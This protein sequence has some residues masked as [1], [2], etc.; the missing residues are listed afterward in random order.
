MKEATTPANPLPVR[1]PGL[2]PNRFPEITYL[3]IQFPNE[4]VSVGDSWKFTRTFEGADMTYTCTLS[5]MDDASAKIAVKVHQEQL[6][7]E[8]SS[9]EVVKSKADA[10][11]EVRTILDGQGTITWDRK[12]GLANVVEMTNDATS[13]VTP[14]S[15]GTAETRKLKTTFRV[16]RQGAPNA[17]IVANAPKA[18]NQW[19]A[20]GEQAWNTTKLWA[21][22]ATNQ[23]AKQPISRQAAVAWQQAFGWAF[24]LWNHGR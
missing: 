20:W 24:K 3:P 7:Y 6:Y 11:N 23:L 8:N 5:S 21:M 16:T 18:Q 19:Q 9:V 15:P 13:T 14:I 10:V 2:D 4:G 22:W 1:L 12:A 17:A